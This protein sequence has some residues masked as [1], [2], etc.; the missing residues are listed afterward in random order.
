MNHLLAALGAFGLS[1]AAVFFRLSAV[2]PATA[3][4][5]RALYALPLLVLLARRHA[6]A[7]RLRLLALLGGMLFGVDLVCWHAAIER[8][9]AGLATVMANTQIAWVTLAAWALHGERPAPRFVAMMPVMLAGVA[10]LAGLGDG[11]AYGSDPVLGT[12]LGLLGAMTY[13]AYL[14]LH[15]Q[16]CRGERQPRGQLRDATLGVA[17]AS[18]LLGGVFDGQFSLQ[19]V[20]PGHAWLLALALVVQVGAWLALS[21]ALPRLPAVEGSTLLLIQPVGTLL[22][23][24]WLFGEAPSPRQWLGAAL[25]LVGLAVVQ[26]APHLRR[27]A[28]GGAVT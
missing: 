8:I 24:R 13:A 6:V 21:A 3:S 15:R 28:R 22:W 17:L 25:V 16:A 4:T 7:P 20:W 1:L 10:L 11:R 26:L 14:L 12:A 19:P 23:G 5:F 18:A 2:S 27:P 9:G